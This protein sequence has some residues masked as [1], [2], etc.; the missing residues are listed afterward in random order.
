MV[1]RVLSKL[2]LD[3]FNKDLRCS[4]VFLEENFEV[5]SCDRSGALVATL[6]L[7]PSKANKAIEIKS[8]KWGTIHFNGA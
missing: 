7:N 6:I 2:I 8:I 4:K 1:L 5:K 3:I